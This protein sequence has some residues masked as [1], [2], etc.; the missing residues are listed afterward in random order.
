MFND[1]FME[2]VRNYVSGLSKE[3]RSELRKILMSK[4]VGR[5]TIFYWF[6]GQHSPH[7]TTLQLFY[8]AV[9]ELAVLQSEKKT[10]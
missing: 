10:Y 1:N 4:K 7:G 6:T 2:T 5:T 8:E 9:A 3:Q